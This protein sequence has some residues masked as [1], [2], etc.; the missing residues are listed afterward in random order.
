MTAVSV[1]APAPAPG[2]ATAPVP[3]ERPALA[4][5]VA[6][7]WTVTRRT[8][9]H[10]RQ[11]P[12]GIAVGLCFPVLTLLMFAYL[13][14]GGFAVPGDGGYEAFLVPGM[15]ALSVLFGI[16]GTV[17]EVVTDASKGITDRFRAMPMAPGALLVGRSAADMATAVIGLV[18]L[19]A[20]GRLI[21]WTWDEGLG[22]A[23]LAVGLLLLLRFA[24]IWVGIYLGLLL[25]TP[26]AAVVVQVLVWPVGFVSNAYVAPSTM[27]GWLGAVSE[28]NPMS[29]TVAATRDL[30]GNPSWGADSWMA[31][32]AVALAVAWPLALLAVFVPL[33]LRRHRS[34]GR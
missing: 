15:L 17:L 24:F 20:T 7:S 5:L 33:A 3:E 9:L 31:E 10:W 23:A 28:A 26:E 1:P 2:A 34:L 32:N 16:E 4:W 22:R 29:A 14:G 6:D 12:W 11:Q 27:P 19:V 8:F 18:T 13:F 21:G 25:K 30:F